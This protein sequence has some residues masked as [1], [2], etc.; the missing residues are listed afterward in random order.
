MAV[1]LMG[2]ARRTQALGSLLAAF[3]LAGCTAAGGLLS[4]GSSGWRWPW[5]AGTRYRYQ[6]AAVY[7]GK[8]LAAIQAEFDQLSLAPSG[9]FVAFRGREPNNEYWLY[10]GEIGGNVR[11]VAR[12]GLEPQ[13]L[14]VRPG[15]AATVAIGGEKMPIGWLND[16]QI[17]FYT[18]NEQDKRLVAVDLP[19]G[20]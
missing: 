20:A 2:T 14:V 17:L 9:R 11:K 13:S 18:G 10:I 6:G 4:P 8:T 15:S 1:I 12:T 16:R 7:E 5:E 19:E 3:T